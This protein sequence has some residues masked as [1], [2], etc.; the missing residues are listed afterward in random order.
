M[1]SLVLFFRSTTEDHQSESPESP[2]AEAAP[3]VVAEETGSDVGEDQQGEGQGDDEVMDMES[4][5]QHV[6]NT[7]V[8]ET[9]RP[10]AV[11]HQNRYA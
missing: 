2:E 11:A 8:V 10:P 7:V 4:G 5:P 6:S 9:A 3:V 1:T